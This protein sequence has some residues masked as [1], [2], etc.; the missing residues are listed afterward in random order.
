M[1]TISKKDEDEDE[2]KAGSRHDNHPLYQA[3][4]ALAVYVD[5][6]F[7]E[8]DP[9]AQHPAVVRLMTSSTL[10]NV[11]LAAALSDDDVDEIGMTIAYLKRA[12]K[13]VTSA[14]DASAQCQQEQLLDHEGIQDLRAT[15]LSG[16]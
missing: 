4:S 15:H 13:A 1:K 6:M 3:A 5:G 2:V 14:L 7:D 9:I 10:A 16:A 12:L 8:R 11:K